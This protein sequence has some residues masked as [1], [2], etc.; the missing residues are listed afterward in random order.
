RDVI[1]DL[2]SNITSINNAGAGSFN[3]IAGRDIIMRD[4]SG[5]IGTATAS[6]NHNLNFTAAR[7]VELNE[8]VYQGTG[9]TL[10]FTA[11]A[12]GPSATG[13]QILAPTGNG[14]VTLQG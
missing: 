12:S 2:G 4:S 14:S 11:N 5:T 9:K 10:N 6:F 3:L 13:N 1:L 8:S 7:S